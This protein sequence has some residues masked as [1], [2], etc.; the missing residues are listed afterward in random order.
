MKE[1]FFQFASPPF[2]L[3]ILSVPLVYFLIHKG[4]GVPR[5]HFS[6]LS[7]FSN[8]PLSRREKFRFV[9]PLMRALALLFL[10]IGMARPQWGNKTTE[11]LSE[12]IDIILSVDTSG[13]MKAL[14]FKLDGNESNRLDVIKKV[15]QDFVLRRPYD[16]IGMIVFG[17]EAYT[18]CPLTL[19]KDTLKTFV[20]W[21]FIGMAG[22]GTAI[23]NGLGLSVKRLKDQKTKSKVIILLTDGRNNAGEVAPLMAA[24]MAKEFGIKV[25]TIGVGTRGPVPYP[26]ETPFGVRRAYARLDL[27]EDT[28]KEIAGATGGLYFRAVDTDE[29][30]KIYGEIDQMEK[31]EVKVKEYSDYQELYFWF[32]LAA[33]FF[34]FLEIVLSQTVFLRIP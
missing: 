15:M 5:I 9:F 25:Y 29:L 23:G 2:F 33:L 4:Y 13:S 16:R 12:G 3:L 30:E 17:D 7:L 22:D 8:I 26:Q 28:L 27:D 18:Q 14:D 34:V 11:T 20:D 1:L 6:S 21:V 24:Q 32:L 10:I 31:T 19:D